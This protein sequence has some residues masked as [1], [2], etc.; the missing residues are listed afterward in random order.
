[1]KIKIKREFVGIGS[2]SKCPQ[3]ILDALARNGI[4]SMD[5]ICTALGNAYNKRTIQYHV[6]DLFEEGKITS[7]M[8]RGT[9]TGTRLYRLAEKKKPD[10][11]E[12]PVDE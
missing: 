7:G 11:A 1:M 3:Q 2:P 5:E 9:S 6:H 4:S 10:T 12:S 8:R